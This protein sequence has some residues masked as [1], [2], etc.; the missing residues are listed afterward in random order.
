[1]CKRDDYHEGRPMI[2][3]TKWGG[4]MV[5]CPYGH[6]YTCMD[7]K[8]WAGSWLEAKAGDPDWTV[9]CYGAVPDGL[10]PAKPA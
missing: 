7:R 6:V 4:I 9:R 3:S 1:M 8:D 5:L 2:R 10:P